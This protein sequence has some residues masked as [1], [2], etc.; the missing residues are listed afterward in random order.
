MQGAYKLSKDF[1]KPYFHKYQTWQ[2]AISSC[3]VS[4][5]TMFTSHHFQRHYQNCESISTPQSGTSHKTRLRG[6]GRNG[7]IA[8]TSAVSHVWRT[9]NAFKVTMKLQTS[10]FQM[11]V[12]SCISVQYLWKHGFAK[13]SGNLYAPCTVSH[14][15]ARTGHP[16]YH[17][18]THRCVLTVVYL[19]N[20]IHIAGTSWQ[21]SEVTESKSTYFNC[22]DFIDWTDVF[23][24]ILRRPQVSPSSPVSN[25]HHTGACSVAFDLFIGK[26]KHQM[27]CFRGHGLITCHSVR[28]TASHGTYDCYAPSSSSVNPAPTSTITDRQTSWVILNR[29]G[30]NARR[31]LRWMARDRTII[32]NVSRAFVRWRDGCKQQEEWTALWTQSSNW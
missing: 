26:G 3:E 32:A 2:C 15:T 31:L 9:S 8:W 16:K 24:L 11:V 27:T 14:F 6:F 29:Y 21:S 7:S 28:R 19:R 4:S 5:R 12:T 30:W 18:A 17:A 20:E 22:V 23:W 13:S 10:L 1:A 25:K